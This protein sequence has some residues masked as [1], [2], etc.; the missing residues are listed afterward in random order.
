MSTSKPVVDDTVSRRDTPVERVVIEDTTIRPSAAAS[1]GTVKVNVGVEGV[2]RARWKE[3]IIHTHLLRRH[4]GFFRATLCGAL[5]GLKD[6][7]ITFQA[8]PET[9]DHFVDWLYQQDAYSVDNTKTDFEV[10]VLAERLVAPKLKALCLDNVFEE[11]EYGAPSLDEIA[12]TFL[13]L[14]EHDPLLRLVV[15]AECFNYGCRHDLTD[16]DKVKIGLIPP[17]FHVKFMIRRNELVHIKGP[18]AERPC[19]KDYSVLG[20]I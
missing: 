8:Q 7:T 9:F 17:M 3:Y 6:G 14:P 11:L 20:W 2:I 15:D 4:S 16:E 19:Q 13:A 10:Y 12:Y 18:R 5:P 1:E